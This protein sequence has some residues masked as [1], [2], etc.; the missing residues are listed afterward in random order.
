M[1]PLFLGS[2]LVGSGQLHAWAALAPGERIMVP[3][4]YEAEW[5]PDTVWTTY[6]REDS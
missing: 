1:D 4:V 5:G 3:V 6:K 2:V